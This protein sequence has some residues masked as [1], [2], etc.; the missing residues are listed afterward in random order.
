MKL[1]QLNGITPSFIL[2]FSQNVFSEKD[3]CE[4]FK[5][6][7]AHQHSPNTHIHISDQGFTA[8]VDVICSKQ[9]VCRLLGDI[10]FTTGMRHSGL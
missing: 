10:L 3:L 5:L 4:R 8:Y 6:A 2:L 9:K 1:K 7:C